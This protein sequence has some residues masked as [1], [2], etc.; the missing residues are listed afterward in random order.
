MKRNRFYDWDSLFSK[1][2]YVC[3]WVCVCVS[4]WQMEGSI[5]GSTIKT[6]A[7]TQETCQMRSVSTH[8]FCWTIEDSQWFGFM[9][10]VKMALTMNEVFVSKQLQ[11]AHLKWPVWCADVFSFYSPSWFLVPWFQSCLGPT[12]RLRYSSLRPSARP[13]GYGSRSGWPVGQNKLN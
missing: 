11:Q 4:R 10:E 12:Q 7:E 2:V 13:S 9:K 5:C 3:L 8:T 1:C 6:S